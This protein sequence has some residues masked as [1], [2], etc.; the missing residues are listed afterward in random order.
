MICTDVRFSG[1]ALVRMFERAIGTDDVLETLAEGEVI[2]EYPDDQPYPSVLL[3]GW[4]GERPLHV[5]AARTPDALCIVITAYI[6]TK[7]HWNHDFK[8]RRDL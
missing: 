3:L 2:A 7:E 4:C 8:T 1:H 6:P 5:V